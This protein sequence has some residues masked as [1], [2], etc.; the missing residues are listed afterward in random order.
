MP[1]GEHK[2]SFK[3]FY[4]INPS[5]YSFLTARV[6]VQIDAH[7][8]NPPSFHFCNSKAPFSASGFQ[9]DYFKT[10]ACNSFKCAGICDSKEPDIS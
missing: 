1:H 10:L 9:R 2:Q 3:S 5:F 4:F 6:F 7:P 8:I